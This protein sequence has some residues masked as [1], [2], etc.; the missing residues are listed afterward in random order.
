[1][2]FLQFQILKLKEEYKQLVLGPMILQPQNSL[3]REGEKGE[4][5]GIDV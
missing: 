5:N 3:W 1:M 2:G 4:E